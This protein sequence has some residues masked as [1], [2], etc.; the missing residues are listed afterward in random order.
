MCRYYYQ[1]KMDQENSVDVDLISEY[2]EADTTITR[3]LEI[4]SEVYGIRFNKIQGDDA[5]QL[6]GTGKGSDIF[7][8]PDQQLYAVWDK[9]SKQQDGY[10]DFKGYIYIDLF[11]RVSLTIAFPIEINELTLRCNA[12]TARVA[13]YT[14]LQS[15]TVTTSKTVQVDSMPQPPRS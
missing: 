8:H 6:S 3:V 2:F 1:T 15:A 4:Y 13:A 5:D 12:R 14:R 9:S 11:V 7:M 10:G